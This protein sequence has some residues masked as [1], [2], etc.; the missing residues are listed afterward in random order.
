MLR[1]VRFIVKYGER[2]VD[3]IYYQ[4]LLGKIFTWALWERCPAKPLVVER[5][6][7]RNSVKKIVQVCK[8]VLLSSKFTLMF[9]LSY[10]YIYSF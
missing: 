10:L 4:I 2:Y 6:F 7:M 8:S 1:E 5:N 3:L 9:C